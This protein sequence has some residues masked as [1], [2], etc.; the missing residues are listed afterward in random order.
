MCRVS[1]YILP[2]LPVGEET[3]AIL[4]RMIDIIPAIL[5]KSFDELKT[6]LERVQ[7]VAPLVQ[8]DAV[9]GVFAPNTT[10][11]LSAPEQFARILSGEEGLPL[12]EKF[13]FQFDLMVAQPLVEAARFVTAGASSVIVHAAGADAHEALESL[14]SMRTVEIAP[15]II[16]VALLPSASLDM[17]ASF[18]G[19]FDFVQVMGIA[20]VGFQHQP[21]APSALSLIKDIRIHYPELHIQADGGVSLERVRDFV[22][23]GATRLVVGSAIFSADDPRKAYEALYVEANR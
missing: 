1:R 4:T 9:D 19:L 2:E 21:F 10:W 15:L 16:G 11:P 3:E 6:N 8:I 18:E 23:A 22:E 17:L 20:T 13:D 12:W 5:A 7:D 14:Q